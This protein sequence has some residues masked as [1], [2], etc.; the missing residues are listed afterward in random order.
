M[1]LSLIP[2]GMFYP[3]SCVRQSAIWFPLNNLSYPKTNRL[4]FINKIMDHKRKAM[5]D[6]GLCHFFRSGVML[7]F[8]L[9]ENG[10]IHIRG[11]IH[12]VLHECVALSFN[13]Y[14]HYHYT[15]CKYKKKKPIYN[16]RYLIP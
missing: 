2:C 10:G 11:H 5:F 8:T 13:I 1:P 12:F 15:F 4:K 6:F 16:L 3:C 7:L 9:T 14:L